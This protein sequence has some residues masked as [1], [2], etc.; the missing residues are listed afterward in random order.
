MDDQLIKE[1]VAGQKE[2]TELLR[3]YLWRLRFSLLGL[4]LLM[5]GTAIGLGI[6]VYEIRPKPLTAAPT[7]SVSG[8]TIPN[9]VTSTWTPYSGQGTLTIS[10]SSPLQTG[11][12]TNGASSTISGSVQSTGTLSTFGESDT[13]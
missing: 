7:F 12:V 8:T 11:V 10:S 13:K 2:Q 5:T 9:S 3:R 6:L 4:F 1:L